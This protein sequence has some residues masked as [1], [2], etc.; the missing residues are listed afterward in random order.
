MDFGKPYHVGHCVWWDGPFYTEGPVKDER[1][2]WYFTTLSG[3]EIMKGKWGERM[4]PWA[5]SSCPNGQVM[6]PCGDLV[7]CDS[8]EAALKRFDAAG[9]F[10]RYEIKD[11]CA[12][13]QVHSPNDVIVDAAGGLY[14][15]DST[16][17]HGKVFY[18]GG[19]GNESLVA[20]GLAY[21]NGLA[22]LE[23]SNRLFVAESYRNRILELKTGPKAK[24]RY[25]VFSDLPQHESGNE[26]DNLP[27]GLA[28]DV[29]GNL[30]VAHYGMGALQV[31]DQHGVLVATIP[32]GMPFTS[33]ICF[34]G[35]EPLKVMVTGGFGEPGPGRVVLITISQQVLR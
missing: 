12:G 17:H 5:S 30:W 7:V 31:L 28:V 29:W 8:K 19:D 20:S 15:T 4:A 21:P 32:T 24:G 6:L 16:R 14:F 2:N 27:D 1:G 33:N 10:L 22:L 34:A 18:K 9:N 35:F 25:Q 3:G 13:E 23:Q 26:A 11:Y